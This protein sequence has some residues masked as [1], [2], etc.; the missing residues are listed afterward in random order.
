ME[1]MLSRILESKTELTDGRQILYDEP[2]NLHSPPYIYQCDQIMMNE[3]RNS[4]SMH[5]VK[6][7]IHKKCWSQKIMQIPLGEPTHRQENILNWILNKGNVIMQ[8]G[9]ISNRI[10]QFTEELLSM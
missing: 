3:M 7:E 9:F 4:I 2:H 6:R 5:G 1:T 8:P 10:Q